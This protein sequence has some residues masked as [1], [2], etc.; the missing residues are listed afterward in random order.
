M[1][2]WIRTI[3][4]YS[5]VTG[6]S[7]DSLS[8]ASFGWVACLNG[9]ADRLDPID[10]PWNMC[11]GDG[12]DDVP[13]FLINLTQCACGAAMLFPFTRRSAF[14]ALDGQLAR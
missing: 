5:S 10:R 9:A 3:S 1:F 14:L 11:A 6:I 12:L 4:V 8:L 13:L 2:S 7:G